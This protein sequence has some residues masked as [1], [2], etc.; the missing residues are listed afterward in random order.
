MRMCVIQG[1]ANLWSSPCLSYELL[2]TPQG[3]CSARKRPAK[4][5]PGENRITAWSFKHPRTHVIRFPAPFPVVKQQDV[6]GNTLGMS[7]PKIR[8]TDD[9]FEEF[10]SELDFL[11]NVGNLF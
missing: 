4:D 2:A 8:N 3:A 9:N 6:S 10:Y 5:G 7:Y 11:S 1:C